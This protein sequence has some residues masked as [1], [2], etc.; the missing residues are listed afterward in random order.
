M[1]EIS[2]IELLKELDNELPKESLIIL[3]GED[4]YL[5]DQIVKKY[6]DRIFGN[7]SNNLDFVKLTGGSLTYQ[8]FINVITS[9][10]F[11]SLKFVLVKDGEQIPKQNL[12]KLTSASIP[13][14][15]KVI[16]IINQK[17]VSIPKGNFIIVKDYTAPLNQIEIWIE[18]KAK[19]YGKTITKDAIKELIRRLDTNFYALSTEIKK[20]A[21]YVGDRKEIRK[22]TVSEIVKE[23]G[24][25]DIFEFVNAIM[26]SRRNDVLRMLDH[27]LKDQ[28][29][30][31]LI[32][33]Q[34]LKT[35]S[36]Y[37]IV[38]DLKNK[39]GVNL[40]AINEYIASIFGTYLRT[41]TL[42][43]I[44]KNLEVANIE[45][46]LKQ[47]SAFVEFDVK[48]KRGEIDLPL[49]LRNYILSRVS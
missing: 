33:S 21:F 32:L 29:Q 11:F 26:F 8:E 44:I 19:E 37:L 49:S 2:A 39:E 24:E 38:N 3:L 17:D 1:R 25:E 23:L 20:L 47:Y 28:G 15:T 7:N 31:N 16:L 45:N 4:H 41:K 36:I 18:K 34:V 14:F 22:E 43:E 12:Q 35:L 40:R 30:E 48:S 42:E 13:D 5:K 46:I 9:P 27:F 10:P 6:V